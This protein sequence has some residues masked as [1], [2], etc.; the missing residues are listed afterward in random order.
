MLDLDRIFRPRVRGGISTLAGPYVFRRKGAF[1]W[2]SEVPPETATLPLPIYCPKELKLLDAVGVR[3]GDLPTVDLIKATFA[4]SPAP[5]DVFA[6]RDRG[7]SQGG[8]R[9]HFQGGGV[10]GATLVDI[11]HDPAAAPRR[12]AARLIRHAR[13]AGDHEHAVSLRDAWQ[14]R[15]AICTIDGELDQ[16]DAEQIALREIQDLQAQWAPGKR[17]PGSPQGTLN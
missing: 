4:Q 2:V 7:Y 15:V 8:F 10:P 14:E 1:G 13:R 9:G 16:V 12:S 5:G 11:W 3:P 6:A 17:V